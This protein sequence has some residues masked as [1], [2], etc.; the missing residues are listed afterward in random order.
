[1]AEERKRGEIVDETGEKLRRK[2]KKKD[3]E[4]TEQV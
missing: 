3:K 4:E 1:M 2:E